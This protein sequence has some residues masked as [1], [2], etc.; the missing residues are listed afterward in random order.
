MTFQ[1][2]FSLALRYN[3]T[4]AFRVFFSERKRWLSFSSQ[5]FWRISLLKWAEQHIFW[6]WFRRDAGISVVN[7]LQAALVAPCV[8]GLK[9]WWGQPVID[10][11]KN[12]SDSK[13]LAPPTKW[14]TFSAKPVWTRN[15]LRIFWPAADSHGHDCHSHGPLWYA[16]MGHGPVAIWLR[17][18]NFPSAIRVNY[19]S[20]HP[21]SPN[22]V[23]QV[24]PVF[25]TK[26]SDFI[27]WV[28]SVGRKESTVDSQESQVFEN[29]AAWEYLDAL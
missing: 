15:S 4:S 16:M 1:P 5:V 13:W 11:T 9:G 19:S 8:E 17:S 12:G 27:S 6:G 22:N 25:G 10:N 20:R 18:R 24:I 29:S 2:T 26:I 3:T 7:V 14:I 23:R 28:S 21:I